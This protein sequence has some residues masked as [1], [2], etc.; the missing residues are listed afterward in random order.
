MSRF[1][2]LAAVVLAA[3][4]GKDNDVDTGT[5][6]DNDSD[7][8][9][10]NEDC[11]DDDALVN[12]DAAEICD[13]IDND[14]DAAIDGLDDDLADGVF[15]Y[16]DE[17]SD[18]FGDDASGVLSCDLVPDAVTLG[19][20]CDDVDPDINPNAQEIC[21]DKDNDCD[22]LTD[23]DDDDTY[24]QLEY[25]VDADGDGWGD[26]KAS[27]ER[28]CADPGSG[29]V[30]Y[31]AATPQD[32]DDSDPAFHPYAKETC[33]DTEDYNCDGSVGYDDAD[34]DGSPACEDCDDAQPASFPGNTEICDGFDNNCNTYIDDLDPDLADGSTFYVDH[35]GDTYGDAGVSDVACVV[36]PGFVDNADDCDDDDND[37]HPGAVE[38]CDRIDGDCDGVLPD[39]ESDADGDGFVECEATSDC[40]DADANIH[41][42][43]DELCSTVGVD[44]DCDGYSDEASAVD[45]A[46]WY[47][48]FDNDDYGGVGGLTTVACTQPSD[49]VANNDDCDDSRAS[50]NPAATELCNGLD[51]NC[52]SVVPSDEVDSDGDTYMT[53]EG[54][55]DDT[56]ASAYPGSLIFYRDVDGD[57]YG[58]ASSTVTDCAAPSGYVDVSGD[59][60][61][62]NANVHPGADEHC[63]TLDDDCNGTID[64]SY[65]V[66]AK[67]WY[68]DTDNDDFGD[69]ATTTASCTRPSGYTPDDTDCDDT[70]DTINPDAV[71]V[72]NDGIDNNCDTVGGACEQDATASAEVVWA[73]ED[74]NDNAGQT[75]AVGGDVDGD[76]INELLLGAKLNDAAGADAGT[77][78]VVWG[79]VTTGLTSLDAVDSQRITGQ[80]NVTSS[81]K[82]GASIAFAGDMIGSDGY[83]DI[84]LGAGYRDVSSSG[85]H[86]GEVY[87]IS[88]ADLGHTTKSVTGFSDEYLVKGASNFDY[89]GSGLVRG[90]DFDGDDNPDL[91]LAATG[92]GSSDVGTVYLLRG[93][94][95][96]STTVYTVTSVASMSITGDVGSDT[97]GS[98]MATGDFDGDGISDLAIGDPKDR[99]PSVG[100]VN[101]GAVHLFLGH[102]SPSGTTDTTGSDAD[103]IA[104]SASD[105]LGGAVANAGDT[106]G[107]GT[108][109]LVAGATGVDTNGTDSGACYVIPGSTDIADLDGVV[110]DVSTATFNG[111]TSKDKA[112]SACA[113]DGDFDGDGETDFLAGANAY[114][115]DDLGAVYLVLGPRTGTWTLDL[116]AGDAAARFIG[117]DNNDQMG[118]HALFTGQVTDTF[119]EGIF[120][121]NELDNLGGVDSGAAYIVFDIGL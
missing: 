98:V 12:P 78:Y 107:D 93:G 44:D 105:Q 1:V 54:D 82:L 60:L 16:S 64:D 76:G 47:Y 89:L 121:S 11:D 113:A 91:W 110:D 29:Y 26:E 2:V 7:G 104:G 9:Y 43:A 59:C 42:G 63:N 66:D 88:G 96:A 45:A 20:D 41:P 69:P 24:G 83:G 3:C 13:G 118:G 10:A 114:D 94:L 102:S 79:P 77:A 90:G 99:D 28:Y 92:A 32:C 57:G 33:S 87:I 86:K 97:I 71:E 116:E 67:L 35:D 101:A 108:D 21:D 22:T 120:F 19:G 80:A 6:T 23:D 72:C 65:A 17:D 51:D 58:L 50:A 68:A 27:P 49:Y 115:S 5:R 106:D 56:D 39:D 8:F 34:K 30:S 55:C 36:P 112:G 40:N 61:D 111:G 37:I 15:Y 84:A 73:G 74:A 81:D 62:S 38:L 48:D 52:D 46:T 117:D 100:L 109:D 95:T 70:T 14:C 4:K 103:V 53:C 18:G 31:D 85:D 75:I 119:N 25:K